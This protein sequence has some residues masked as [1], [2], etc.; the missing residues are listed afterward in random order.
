MLLFFFFFFF[1][2]FFVWILGPPPPPPQDAT[3]KNTAPRLTR[4]RTGASPI[5]ASSEACL[6]TITRLCRS[7]LRGCWPGSQQHKVVGL[8][9][10]HRT[11]TKAAKSPGPCGKTEAD[12]TQYTRHAHFAK[13]LKV[14]F[15]RFACA[16]GVN[17]FFF[18][19]FFFLLPGPKKKKMVLK[20]Q[21]EF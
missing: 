21:R 10:P 17:F 19:F 6:R 1:F 14:L 9:Q 15:H 7:S 13:L 4:V 2:F 3:P 20:N 11:K 5:A 16:H 12:D 18:F 8:A